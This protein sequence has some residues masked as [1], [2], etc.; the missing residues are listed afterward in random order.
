[1]IAAQYNRLTSREADLAGAEGML[2][3]AKAD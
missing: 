3:E 2:A 1:V